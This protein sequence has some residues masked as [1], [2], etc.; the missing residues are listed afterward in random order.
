MY[1]SRDLQKLKLEDW[2]IHYYND[3]NQ[4]NVLLKRLHFFHTD[5]MTATIRRSPNKRDYFDEWADP[6]HDINRLWGRCKKCKEPL[7]IKATKT[8]LNLIDIAATGKGA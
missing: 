7:P 6:N 1:S 2:I 4:N 5:C 3:I 8:W